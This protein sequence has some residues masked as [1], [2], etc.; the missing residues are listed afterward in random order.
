MDIDCPVHLYWNPFKHNFRD[1]ECS[2]DVG[3]EMV[4]AFNTKKTK[5]SGR[6][7]RNAKESDNDETTENQK[8]NTSKAN[9]VDSSEEDKRKKDG[10]TA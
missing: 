2:R 5:S 1:W 8:R 7:G 10:N 6:R 9:V 3:A 4:R